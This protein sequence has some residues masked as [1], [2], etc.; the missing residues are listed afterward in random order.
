MEC[1]IIGGEDAVLGFGMVGVE[2]V[3][4]KRPDDAERA[5]RAALERK[6]V[7]IILMTE[8]VAELIRP[9]VDEYVF[10]AE[11][12]LI[13]EIPDR[14]GRIEGKPGLR[15]TVNRAIGITL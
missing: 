7:G 11:F 9:L 14:H 8:H 2:G 15:E 5:F 10:T 1:F 4:A 12:P 6:E 13:V 3:A